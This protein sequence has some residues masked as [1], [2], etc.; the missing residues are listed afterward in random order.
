MVYEAMLAG[1]EMTEFPVFKKNVMNPG[2][3]SMTLLNTV[4]EYA[5][6]LIKW[7]VHS[8][9]RP[10]LL[11]DEGKVPL[12]LFTRSVTSFPLV[13]FLCL[14]W[15]PRAWHRK[16]PRQIY[17]HQKLHLLVMHNQE[18][19][20]EKPFAGLP[21]S[22]FGDSGRQ[23]GWW[24]FIRR[25]IHD[26]RNTDKA[27][28]SFNSDADLTSFPSVSA[29]T[30][31]QTVPDTPEPF[32]TPAKYSSKLDRDVQLEATN[33]IVLETTYASMLPPESFELDLLNH[34]V[35]PA[36]IAGVLRGTNVK[37]L[38]ERLGV[39]FVRKPARRR[40]DGITDGNSLR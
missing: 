9:D 14:I 13:P 24:E 25:L 11:D 34:D 16:R 39:L 23:Y 8:V 37:E 6:P 29:S 22:W 28:Y 36:L 27:V 40:Y 20:P 2:K 10:P 3:G 7:E 21:D 35:I 4:W 19:F 26:Q 15:L 32:S 12:R 17:D 5:Y 33:H 30:S 18:L 38:L 31:S 1:L